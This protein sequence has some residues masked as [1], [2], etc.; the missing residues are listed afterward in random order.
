MLCFNMVRLVIA[1]L[2]LP[3]AARC[4]VVAILDDVVV[5]DVVGAAAST[6]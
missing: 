2:P 5:T 3:A 4:I 6:V 1:E